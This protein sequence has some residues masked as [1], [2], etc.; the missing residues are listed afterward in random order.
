MYFA[1]LLDSDKNMSF[2]TN[3]RP[4]NIGFRTAI[5]YGFTNE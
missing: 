1:C 2:L 3:N 5:E 4:V